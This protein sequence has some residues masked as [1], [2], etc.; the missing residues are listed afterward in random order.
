MPTTAS[1]NLLI[2]AF[3][4][5]VTFYLYK[6]KVLWDARIFLASVAMIFWAYWFTAFGDFIAIP[7]MG[8]VTVFL[9]LTSPRKLGVLRGAD[10][11]YGV[12]LYGYPIQQAF[13]ALGPW[14]HNWLLNG[15]VCSIVATCFAALSWRF[16]EKPALKLRKQV[17][18]LE[19]LS[20]QRGAKRQ[21]AAAVAK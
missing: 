10:Y 6:D 5:G 17:T 15:I 7:A 1:G 18:W 2:C 14:A 12:F 8:Y 4:V 9:G 13:V 19:N 11:S 21:L 20:L 16:I 3:L